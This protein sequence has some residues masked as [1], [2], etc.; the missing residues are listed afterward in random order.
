MVIIFGLFDRAWC[1]ESLGVNLLHI[2][3][4]FFLYIS[5][6][7]NTKYYFFH[8]FQQTFYFHLQTILTHT[9]ITTIKLQLK[10]DENQLFLQ[11]KILK[12]T[13]LTSESQKIIKIT[14]SKIFY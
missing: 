2:F 7:V 5:I 1:G 3:F 9:H 12:S 6:F 8:K 11:S 13:L 4:F 14:V 10:S